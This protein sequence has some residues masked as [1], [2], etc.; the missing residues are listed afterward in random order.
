MC[1]PEA[2]IVA[3][4]VLSQ[5]TGYGTWGM[6]IDG[7]LYAADIDADVINMSL[8][9]DL[10]RRGGWDD[11]G[12]PDED[13]DVWFTASEVAATINALKRAVAYAHASGAVVV[14]AAG[15]SA[16]D[17]DHDQDLVS[18]PAQLPMVLAIS[19]TVADRLGSRTRPW[20]STSSRPTRTTVSPRSTSPRPAATT[21]TAPPGLR[22]T[23][24]VIGAVPM[25]GRCSAGRAW[26]LRTSRASQR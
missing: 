23:I 26:R 1:A 12:T 14:A 2:E 10:N 13:D 9:G 11:N 21:R 3:V 6:V 18:L 22:V 5:Y 25:G 7:I 8:G 20:I 15:N 24:Y 4:K 17:G 19:A 16:I